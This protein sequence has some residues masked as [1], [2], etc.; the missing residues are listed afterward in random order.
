MD[1]LPWVLFAGV[2][3]ALVL[4]VAFFL[5]SKKPNAASDSVGQ[6]VRDLRTVLDRLER[7]ISDNDARSFNSA[8]ERAKALRE[9]VSLQ[10]SRS[11]ET[12]TKS[13]GAV[14]DAQGAQLEAF[15]GA[16][17]NLSN[18]LIGKVDS[19]QEASAL[20]AKGLR[21][22]VQTTLKT[23]GD[24][25]RQNAEAAS[26]TQKERLEQVSAKLTELGDGIAKGFSEFRSGTE[27]KLGE[28][29]KNA[30]DAAALLREEVANSLKKVGDDLRENAKLMAEEQ[31]NNLNAMVER[32]GEI[33]KSS[34]ES[35]ERLRE[36][37]AEG[38]ANL[39]QENETKL[40]AIRV[41]VDEK[42]QG[43]LEKRLGESFK[44]V[45][46][47]LM[48]VHQGLGD[49]QKLA[50]GVGDLKRVLTNVKSRGTWGETQL[51]GLLEDML[52]P[53]QYEKNVK[54]KEDSGE[55]VEFCVKIP[56]VDETQDHILLPVDAK[57]PIEDY[58]RLLEAGEIGDSAA[59]EQARQRLET[60]FRNSA[61]DIARKYISP[62]RT[63]EYAILYVPSEG[64]Y[65]EMARRPGLSASLTRDFNV[66]VAG[67]I[68]LMA[69]LNAIQAVT[70]SVT[71]Q[72]KAGEIATLLVRVQSEFVKYGD[73]VDA[74]RRKAQGVVTA[75][76][77]LG[78]RQRAIGR[79][80]RNVKAVEG[81]VLNAQLPVL[82]L[83]A[84]GNDEVESATEVSDEEEEQ[85]AARDDAEAAPESL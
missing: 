18:T 34:H 31:R 20:Q 2:A 7:S 61:Q 74:A 25:L 16:L 46:E 71:I 84:E 29:S 53:G 23:V 64:L 81:A 14:G 55:T 56:V 75:I 78:T 52:A 80:L 48:S 37:V 82:E 57:F 59:V 40:E 36:S 41:T 27:T 12:L 39:R 10:L 26:G 42:L 1:I 13:L 65:A 68:N 70:K 79:V 50:T 32:I 62:P 83:E 66:V 5:V 77:K 6:D 69:I 30:T 35:Q 72:Q 24:D 19:A 49:M 4:L 67:P 33:G 28:M 44:L 9:E 73:A 51:A 8:E 76:D 60:R 47:Q 15:S 21:E 58:E 3:V 17:V 63:T 85:A 22:E 38:L 54:T 43:T 11:T 45:S